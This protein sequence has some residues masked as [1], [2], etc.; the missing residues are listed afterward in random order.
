LY[1]LLVG[2]DSCR[3][4]FHANHASNYFSLSGRLPKDRDKMLTIIDQVRAGNIRLKPE[5]CRGL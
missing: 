1:G 4:Q 3:T 5:T 2:L